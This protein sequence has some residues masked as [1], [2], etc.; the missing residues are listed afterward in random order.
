MPSGRAL[1]G[2]VVVWDAG[3]DWGCHG[4]WR[5][6]GFIGD[7][8]TSAMIAAEI[9]G[10]FREIGGCDGSVNETTH[11]VDVVTSDRRDRRLTKRSQ[12]D[13]AIGHKYQSMTLYGLHPLPS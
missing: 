11:R 5:C 8:V 13:D 6:S 1:G 7:W 2:F 3:G 4:D 10:W 9:D 12:T